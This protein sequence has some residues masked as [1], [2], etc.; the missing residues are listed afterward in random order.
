MSN[1][2]FAALVGVSSLVAATPALAQPSANDGHYEW[3]STV[4][5]GPRSP[6]S[7]PQRVWVGTAM[8]PTTTSACDCMKTG[9]LGA[10]SVPCT[11]KQSS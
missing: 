3:R 7:A 11:I 9:A 2:F 5:P 4:Q 8:M 6:V 10:V 1:L